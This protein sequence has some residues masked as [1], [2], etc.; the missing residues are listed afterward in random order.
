MSKTIERPIQPFLNDENIQL[1]NQMFGDEKS[2]IEHMRTLHVLR[3]LIHE[4]I[5]NK[6]QLSIEVSPDHPEF[7]IFKLTNEL[8]DSLFQKGYHFNSTGNVI[9]TLQRTGNEKV[10]ASDL[11]PVI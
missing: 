11:L 7:R 10:I 2:Y 8:I 4:S 9:R 1:L 5:Q 6:K 3:K